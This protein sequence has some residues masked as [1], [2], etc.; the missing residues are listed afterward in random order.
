MSVAIPS[1]LAPS[2]ARVSA[3]SLPRT[4]EWPFTWATSC[5]RVSFIG[6]F[7]QTKEIRSSLGHDYEDDGHCSG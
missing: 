5:S 1:P 7:L 2:F 6:F 4:F 3:V